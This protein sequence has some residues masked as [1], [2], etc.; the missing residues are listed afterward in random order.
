M[1]PI[2]FSASHA[3]PCNCRSAR[4][5]CAR[6]ASCRGRRPRR[7]FKFA[8]RDSG[9]YKF[10]HALHD[11][12]VGMIDHAAQ[13]SLWDSAIDLYRVPMLLVHVITRT[14]LLVAIA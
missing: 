9:P 4:Y 7:L 12:I 14:H 1:P 6:F 11:Q 10:W 5:S 3:T 8:A 13:F 2:I